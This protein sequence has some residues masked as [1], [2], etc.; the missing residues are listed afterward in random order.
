MACASLDQLTTRLLRRSR[1][2]GGQPRR[3]SSRRGRAGKR[4]RSIDVRYCRHTHSYANGQK[5]VPN[6]G[7]ARMLRVPLELIDFDIWYLRKKGQVEVLDTGLMAVSVEE[8][9]HV[10]GSSLRLSAGH[11]FEAHRPTAEPAQPDQTPTLSGAVSHEQRMALARS[12]A[13]PPSQG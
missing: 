8:V 4:R 10:E 6:K 1:S 3:K 12:S 2:A 13:V 5:Q 9:D 7:F 11:L